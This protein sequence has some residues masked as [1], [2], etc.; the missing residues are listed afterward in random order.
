MKYNKISLWKR[1]VSIVNGWCS[2]KQY[3]NFIKKEL[4]LIYSVSLSEK[5]INLWNNYAKQKRFLTIFYLARL[6][7]K[8]RLVTCI[9]PLE[10]KIWFFV[11]VCSSVFGPELKP[12]QV[13]M[14]FL[15]QNIPPLNQFEP[16]KLLVEQVYLINMH[17]IS[18]PSGIGSLC[19]SGTN[20]TSDTDWIRVRMLSRQLLLMLGKLFAA[21]N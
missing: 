12:S 15:S 19:T 21:L 17:S 10:I 8:T 13:P 5:L 3:W 1:Q 2:E 6:L 11:L 9:T 18:R 7:P 16:S 4:H 14:W 20:H